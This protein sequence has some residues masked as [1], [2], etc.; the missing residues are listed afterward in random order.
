MTDLFKLRK[1]HLYHLKHG[2]LF[3]T[4]S[5][6]TVY[7]GTKNISFIGPKIWNLLP[8]ELKN[9]KSLKTLKVKNQKLEF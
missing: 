7:H 2:F 4:V 9:T 1:D 3:N 8:N 5:M 6:D